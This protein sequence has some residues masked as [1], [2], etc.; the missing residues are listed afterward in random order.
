MEPLR[1][2]IDFF[3]RTLFSFIFWSD[4]EHQFFHNVGIYGSQLLR[5]GNKFNKRLQHS[6][7]SKG[8]TFKK[9]NNKFAFLKIGVPCPI[10]WS[11]D[12]FT[13]LSSVYKPLCVGCKQKVTLC[14]RKNWFCPDSNLF[15]LLMVSSYACVNGICNL[16]TAKFA[17][18]TGMIFKCSTREHFRD[19]NIPIR[20]QNWQWVLPDE[21]KNVLPV[22]A[23]KMCFLLQ[24]PVVAVAGS[25]AEM[26]YIRTSSWHCLL[27]CR[28]PK[29]SFLIC[30]TWCS[31]TFHG[32]HKPFLSFSFFS[33]VVALQ[34]LEEPL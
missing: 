9:H 3:A 12:N 8:V 28:C 17:K 13:Q 1:K 21:G 6:A 19:I 26:E 5:S 20:N 15:F 10:D 2:S 32:T 24:L 4:S 30:C 25:N 16:W 18:A 23:G 34:G 31:C 14:N 33:C 22:V 29:F 11:L 7:K 27:G